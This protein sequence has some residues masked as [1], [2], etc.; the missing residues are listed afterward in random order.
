M[1]RLVVAQVGA[2]RQPPNSLEV[3]VKAATGGQ[4]FRVVNDGYCWGSR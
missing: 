4:R 2:T 1:I 3:D